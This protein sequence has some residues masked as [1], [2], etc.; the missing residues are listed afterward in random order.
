MQGLIPFKMQAPPAK[1]KTMDFKRLVI[2][3]VVHV[4]TFDQIDGGSI[5]LNWNGNVVV[6]R[7]QVSVA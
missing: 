4:L 3:V 6:W 5:S 7:I 2:L 1:L